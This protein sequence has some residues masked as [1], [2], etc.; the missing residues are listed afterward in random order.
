MSNINSIQNNFS[1]ELQWSPDFLDMLEHI[2]TKEIQD[3]LI[4]VEKVVVVEFEN[5]G[6]EI[7]RNKTI[8]RNATRNATK[9]VQENNIKEIFDKIEKN[10][11][12]KKQLETFDAMKKIIASDD[13]KNLPEKEHDVQF[14]K[15]KDVYEK[16]L[17]KDNDVGVSFETFEQSCI[18]LKEQNKKLENTKSKSNDDFSK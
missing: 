6:I 3:A 16:F 18:K 10:L 7:D 12:D 17:I 14:S 8:D 9:I 1:E 5:K 2:S 11:K 13:Y 15:M 4:A